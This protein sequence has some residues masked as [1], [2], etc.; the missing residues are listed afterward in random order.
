MPPGSPETA[1]PLFRPGE[2]FALDAG[3]PV[4]LYHQLEK[5][6]VDR[7]TRK[8]SV[9]RMLPT[10][11][12]LV[13]IFGVSRATVTKTVRNLVAK[14]LVERKRAVGTRVIRREITEDLGRLK[15]FT[16]EMHGK[17]LSVCTEVID[18]GVYDPE[19]RIA[20]L[21]ALEAGERTLRIRRL[22]GTSEF[23]PI[24]LLES[25]IPARCG[26]D[27]AED[28]SGSLYALLETKYR[29]PIE[30]AE[31]EIRAARADEDHARWLRLAPG[32]TVL[33]MERVSFTRDNRPVEFVR[34]VY[35]SERYRF[36]I[37]LKR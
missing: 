25:Q 35:N 2:R 14:G 5:A 32:E 7:I 29:L 4:P 12:D 3:S 26:V 20:G 1:E 27:P 30:W 33:V 28:F 16:E 36:S 13:R 18:A 15:S 22:R 6:L 37:R 21:L 8:D 10:E 34:G 23:F 24:V 19:D 11:K 31:E 9:G 17:G